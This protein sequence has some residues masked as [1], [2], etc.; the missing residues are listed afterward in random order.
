[1]KINKIVESTIKINPFLLCIP[2]WSNLEL[3]PNSMLSL[4]TE[5]EARCEVL[6]ILHTVMVVRTN[7]V[8]QVSCN[9]DD[10]YNKLL[11][12]KLSLSEEV[13]WRGVE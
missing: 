8:L 3:L 13:G 4:E 12:R 9:D 1:M 6:D 5:E 2:P 11:L 10:R 7:I